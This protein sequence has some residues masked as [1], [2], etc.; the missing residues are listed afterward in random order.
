MHSNSSFM[1]IWSSL[2]CVLYYFSI[3]NYFVGNNYPT[4][5][6]Q[7]SVDKSLEMSF[8]LA[9][10]V[11]LSMFVKRY[12]PNRDYSPELHLSTVL[13]DICFYNHLY[14]TLFQKHSKSEINKS[15]VCLLILLSHTS[16]VET[17][18]TILRP[19]TSSNSD[20]M[21][22]SIQPATKYLDFMSPS[23]CYHCSFCLVDQN[24][25][26]TVLICDPMTIKMQLHEN[27]Q[28]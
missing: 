20:A 17:S 21:Y 15:T 12:A 14:G 16:L 27:R 22:V 8:N 19:V 23:I 24:P 26:F 28:D 25:N 6:L 2:L 1:G 11:P 13:S 10:L 5:F 9:F 7:V 4:A 18:I 3:I